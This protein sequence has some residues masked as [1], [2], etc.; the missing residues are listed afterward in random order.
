MSESDP[1]LSFCING[2]YSLAVL[3][4][5]C[6]NGITGRRPDNIPTATAYATTKWSAFMATL[7]N[8]SNNKRSLLRRDIMATL[9]N[10]SNNKPSLIIN[11]PTLEYLLN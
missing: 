6:E 2:E 11:V 5:I 8:N 7:L 1:K 9:L 10:N 3:T 4:V